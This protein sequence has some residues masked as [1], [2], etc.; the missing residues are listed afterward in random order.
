MLVAVGPSLL[1]VPAGTSIILDADAG[2][3][4]P[5]AGD[6]RELAAMRAR[7]EQRREQRERDIA[8]AQTDCHL[9]S[10]ERIEVFANL[11]GTAADATLAVSQGAEGCGLLR[12][13]FLFL[14][15]DHRAR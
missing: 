5:G 15:R 11:T 8:A 9:A 6:A 13:E 3:V 1:D 2:R 12:T 7:L 14:E 10:G 4:E